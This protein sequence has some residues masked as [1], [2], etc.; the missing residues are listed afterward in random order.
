MRMFVVADTKISI[1]NENEDD[2][3]LIDIIV[4]RISLLT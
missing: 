4:N 3:Q 2:I 1:Q